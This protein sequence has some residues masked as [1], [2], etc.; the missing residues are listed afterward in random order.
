MILQVEEI[1]GQCG[2]MVMRTIEVL[3][4]HKS[5]G[6]SK[7]SQEAESRRRNSRWLKYSSMIALMVRQRMQEVGVTQVM[8]ADRL[9][10]T[11]QHVSMLLKGSSNLTLETI[12]KLEEAL[13]FNI[14]GDAIIPVNGY[15][16]ENVVVRRSYL[17]DSEIAPYAEGKDA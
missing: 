12:A 1:C 14:I 10:C 5:A 3:N 15:K 4:K 8:L 9:G 13:D 11:Q 2:M 6:P 7:W 17:S 16:Q